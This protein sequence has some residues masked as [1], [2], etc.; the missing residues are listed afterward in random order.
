MISPPPDKDLGHSQ[1]LW[2]AKEDRLRAGHGH[3]D[4]VY[5]VKSKSVNRR[6]GMFMLEA[7]KVGK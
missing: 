5:L 3:M 6:K 4:R 2:L 1:F 7:M